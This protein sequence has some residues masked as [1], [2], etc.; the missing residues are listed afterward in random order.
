MLDCAYFLIAAT[1]I[2][3]PARLPVNRAGAQFLT[4]RLNPFDRSPTRLAIE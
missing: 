2:P 1:Y 4:E 3:L